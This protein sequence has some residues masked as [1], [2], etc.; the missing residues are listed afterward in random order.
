MRGTMTVQ[1]LSE[2]E[3]VLFAGALRRLVQAEGWVTDGEIAGIE[4]L[5]TTFGFSDLDDSLD[6]F[7]RRVGRGRDFDSQ[8]RSVTNPESRAFILERLTEV[9]LMD[10]YRDRSE[11]AFLE[12]LK[13]LWA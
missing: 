6:E 1:Q 7:A 8:A 10:G 5:R 2:D 11:E 3:R 4:E 12:H 13:S 9:S